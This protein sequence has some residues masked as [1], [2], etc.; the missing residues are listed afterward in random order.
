MFDDDWE[1]GDERNN[2]ERAKQENPNGGG[3]RSVD[4]GLQCIPGQSVGAAIVLGLAS[5]LPVSRRERAQE[6]IAD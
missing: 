5:A 4:G 3:G 2:A 6:R 1:S